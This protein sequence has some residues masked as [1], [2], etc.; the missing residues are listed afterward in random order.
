[1]R[2]TLLS[3]VML[4]AAG[5]PA[6]AGEALL[7]GRVERIVLLP[8]GVDA[9]PPACPA[10]APPGPD[11]RVRVCVS[12]AG[13]CQQTT[14][15]VE[16]VVLGDTRPGTRQFDARIGEWGRPALPAIHDPILV[17]VREDGQVRWTSLVERDGQVSF[18]VAPLGNDVV[19]GVAVAK[20]AADADGRAPLDLLVQRAR[21][22]R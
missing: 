19:G 18:A 6:L 10:S 9:C 13:G 8:A 5:A 4:L 3:A 11:G 1:M 16:R 20:L 21:A 22:Q 7:V 15:S 2:N 17:H 12:N 14:F